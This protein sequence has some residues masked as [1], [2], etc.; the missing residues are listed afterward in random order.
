MARSARD[1]VFSLVAV[2]A[3]GL[4]LC[5]LALPIDGRPHWHS[6][7]YGIPGA[8]LTFNGLRGLYRAI[9]RRDRP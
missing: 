2:S 6:A 9:T 4:F 8:L 7:A 5:S 1:D 3:I